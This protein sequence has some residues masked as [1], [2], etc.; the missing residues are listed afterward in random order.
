MPLGVPMCGMSFLWDHPPIYVT[1][2][3]GSYFSD[4]DG[5]RYL[6]VNL[7]ITVASAGHTPEPVIRAVAER[8][9][10]GTQFQLPTE[11]AIAVSEELARRW[12]MPK[13]QYQ[14]SS[15]QA[16]TDAVHLAR[17]ATGR[18][19]VVVFEGKYHGHLAELLAV[20][21][22]DGTAPEYLGI[23]RRMLPGRLSLTGMIW[24][25]SLGR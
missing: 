3:V 17:A 8:M 19:R 13:W 4:V 7:G 25:A 12:G 5:N 23:T 6:D 14:L 10:A 20:R 9:A 21:D 18:E 22:G 2:A 24:T 11:D 1:S 16:V 15:T